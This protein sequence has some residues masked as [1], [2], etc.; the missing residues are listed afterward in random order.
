MTGLRE[1]DTDTLSVVASIL[2]R[3]EQSAHKAGNSLEAA[4]HGLGALLAQRALS[5][6]N[7]GFNPEVTE[8][9]NRD[10]DA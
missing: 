8:M 7:L 5:E 3:R 1:L 4:C 10:E 6:R 9:L 2:A